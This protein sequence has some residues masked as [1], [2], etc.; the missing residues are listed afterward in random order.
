MKLNEKQ[1]ENIRLTLMLYY[2]FNRKPPSYLRLA[3]ETTE[4]PHGLSLGLVASHENQEG[5]KDSATAWLVDF[6]ESI[7]DDSDP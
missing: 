2:D 6:I 1:I 4:F 5:A 3:H 7:L